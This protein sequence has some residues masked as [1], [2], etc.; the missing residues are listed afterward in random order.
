M[1]VTK[2]VFGNMFW[3]FTSEA[4]SKGLTFAGSIYLARV[5]GKAGFGLF[6]LAMAVG[7]YF[8]TVVDMGVIGYGTREIAKNREKAAELYSILNSL[9]F[10]L[11][12]VLF[13][14][15]CLTLFYIN[16][17]SEKKLILLAGCFYIVA[18]SLSPDWVLR[19][20][21]KMQFIAFGSLVSSLL[22]L[23]G[24]FILVKNQSGT[25][26][27]SLVY[28][29]SF[30]AGSLILMVY[31][32][33]KLNIPFSFSL[34]FKE[35]RRHAKESFYFAINSAFNNISIFIPIFFMGIWSTADELGAFSAPHR[36]STLIT[37]ASLLV[38]AALYPVL[39]HLYVNN[40][41]LFKKTHDRFQKMVIWISMPVCIIAT[42]LSKDIIIFLFGAAYADSAGIFNILVW[43]S[44]LMT[45][46]YTFGN[47]L[48]S[49]GF[50]RFNMYATGSGMLIV[51]LVSAVSIPRYGS[52]GAVWSLIAGEVFTLVLMARLFRKKLYSSD[53]LSTYLIK[54]L[55]VT[56]VLG[57]FIWFTH[58]KVIFSV[59]IG[60]AVYGT[61]S[62]ITGI[63]NKAS[64]QKVYQGLIH[65]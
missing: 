49:A 3:I 55:F 8:W 18:Y 32:S 59:I 28:S 38:I 47:A 35:W 20:L 5:L 16:M 29:S 48:F 26:F 34:S 64:I 57:L 54:V 31:L 36:L 58:F 40:V 50:Q 7:I 15:F 4:T 9:R 37:R 41:P 63:I 33:R 22:F 19:G 56:F 27:A 51:V 30:L 6:S 43:L 25:F 24:I 46:R 53:T 39:S 17:P 13:L 65:R 14:F 2:R 60:I 23:I 44:F 11:A 61:L 42:L 10:A 62:L 45:L 12:V 1:S 21:E 52:Y